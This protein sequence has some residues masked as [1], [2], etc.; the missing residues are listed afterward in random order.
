MFL[1]LS[2]RIQ[3]FKHI[4]LVFL[5][6]LRLQ[7]RSIHPIRQGNYRRILPHHPLMMLKKGPS[8]QGSLIPGGESC[9]T[10]IFTCLIWVWLLCN[11]FQYSFQFLIMVILGGSTTLSPSAFI[12]ILLTNRNWRF[13]ELNY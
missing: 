13:L 7:G 11:F 6:N 10:Y 5:N 12:Q 9:Y 2:P 1:I 3:L 4:Q 8:I